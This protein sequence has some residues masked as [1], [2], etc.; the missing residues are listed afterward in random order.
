[1]V[2]LN[3]VPHE[4][5]KSAASALHWMAC[6][7]VTEKAPGP[8]DALVLDSATRMYA[9][10]GV[11]FDDGRGRMLTDV[12][13]AVVVRR[14]SHGEEPIRE[15]YTLP[16]SLEDAVVIIHRYARRFADG[17]SPYNAEVCNTNTRLLIA[18]GIDLNDT[19]ASE[20]TLWA[21]GAGRAGAES[22]A[23]D[24]RIQPGCSAAH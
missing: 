13:L 11:E 22:R 20:G 6:R 17:G 19:Q 9:S 5:M 18:A 21:T 3:A 7:W 1:V 2:V 14:D 23:L 16:I 12:P 4:A 10:E 24:E 8:V 15:A